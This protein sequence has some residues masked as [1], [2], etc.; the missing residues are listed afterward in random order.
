MKDFNLNTANQDEW[1]TP[2]MLAG[3]CTTD[4]CLSMNSPST[5]QTSTTTFQELACG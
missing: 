3:T 1:L 5:E 4:P 2:Q